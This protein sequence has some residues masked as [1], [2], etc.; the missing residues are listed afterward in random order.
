MENVGKHVD[1]HIHHDSLE[2]FSLDIS[3][4]IAHTFYKI[5]SARDVLSHKFNP[6]DGSITVIS[7]S[8][9]RPSQNYLRS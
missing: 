6:L 5:V 3:Q 9:T 1:L 2:S 8:P 4:V 7:A